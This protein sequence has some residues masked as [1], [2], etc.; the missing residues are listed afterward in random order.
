[1]RLAGLEVNECSKFMAKSPT[2]EHHSIYFPE[3]KLRIP[4][5][6]NGI[7]SYIP[8]R[9]PTS[10]ELEEPIDMLE[11]TPNIPSWDPH[12]LIY[13]KQEES[14]LKGDGTVKD[15]PRRKFVIS[16]VLTEDMDPA[17]FDSK[18]IT[19]YDESG[20]VHHGIY[21]LKQLMVLYQN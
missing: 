3:D 8:V 17:T 21:A 9:T 11:L 14:M 12:N 18:I 19:K 4:L 20:I 16:S 7:I 1:M 15:P 2:I 6:L 5:S 13:S 10:Q